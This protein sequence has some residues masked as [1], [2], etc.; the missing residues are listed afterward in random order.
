M[1]EIEVAYRK[2]QKTV[3]VYNEWDVSDNVIDCNEPDR[4]NIKEYRDKL[5]KYNDGWN[6]Y[7]K[8][9]GGTQNALIT[10]MGILKKADYCQFSRI[11]YPFTN[12][13]GSHSYDEHKL[14]RPYRAI[15]TLTAGKFIKQ[16]SKVKLTPRIRTIVKDKLNDIAV[17][18]GIDSDWIVT[19]LIREADNMRGRGADRIEAIKLL[20]RTRGVELEKQN[21]NQV[22]MNQP[23]F[24]QFNGNIQDERRRTIESRNELIELTEATGISTLDEERLVEEFSER[25]PITSPKEVMKEYKE[26]IKER[27]RES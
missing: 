15:E 16:T 2:T 14:S 17:Q 19:R 25:P 3:T 7:A 1:I 22:V 5:V 20:A 8:I 13:S 23:L 10:G 18:Y 27:E 24:Q 6:L 4:F 26:Q 12:Y 9:R 11:Q 21:T